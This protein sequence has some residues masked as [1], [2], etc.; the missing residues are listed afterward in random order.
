MIGPTLFYTQAAMHNHLIVCLAIGMLAAAAVPVDAAAQAPLRA[1]A[2]TLICDTSSDIGLIV[3]A[4]KPL[5]C[6][7]TP[8]RPGP[9]EV[10]AGAIVKFGADVAKAAG[11]EM[12]WS[13][14]AP[15]SRRFGILAGQYGGATAKKTAGANSLVGGSASAVTLQ[16]MVMEGE[17]GANLAASVVALELQPA[18]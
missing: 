18:R 1:K 15:A 10:Y 5:I 8:A 2:G 3:A 11:A 14:Y 7:F 9:R 16:P 17:G 13:V 6:L 4:K 12:V